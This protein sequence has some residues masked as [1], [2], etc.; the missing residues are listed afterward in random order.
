MVVFYEATV[1]ARDAG[2]HH[3]VAV[4]SETDVKRRVAKAGVQLARPSG[5]AVVEFDGVV[6]L[7]K[8]VSA[9]KMGT[10]LVFGDE[11]V[12]IFTGAGEGSGAAAA[13]AER[14][15]LGH[16]PRFTQVALRQSR[17]LQLIPPLS[18]GSLLRFCR[19]ER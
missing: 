16:L 14:E 10:R 15:S 6:G 3:G 1:F 9:Q 4:S 19:R 5:E 13:G 2:L 8:A 17:P 18:S 7:N 12:G 11:T